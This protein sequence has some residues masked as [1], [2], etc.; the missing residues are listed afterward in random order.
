M[1]DWGRV[2]DADGFDIEPERIRYRFDMRR[3]Y[4]SGATRHPQIEIRAIAPDARD[5]EPH[6]IGDCWI[7]MATK[8]ENPP[9]WIEALPRAN[10][11]T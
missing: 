4:E 2:L 3:A 5:F 8:I 1:S 7:F 6:T 10:P 9:A 11:A